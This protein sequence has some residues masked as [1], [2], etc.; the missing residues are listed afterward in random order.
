MHDGITRAQDNETIA[1]YDPKMD[2]FVCLSYQDLQ[3]I[4]AVML[5]CKD[6]GGVQTRT[7]QEAMN[8]YPEIVQKVQDEQNQN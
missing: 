5:Q 2:K 8:K 7:L 6:W 4:F 3:A 1:C